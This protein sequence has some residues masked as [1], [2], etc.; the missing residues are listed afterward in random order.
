MCSQLSRCIT[1]SSSGQAGLLPSTSPTPASHQLSQSPGWEGRSHGQLVEQPPWGTLE[2]ITWWW[3]I[4]NSY[5]SVENFILC[6]SKQIS[7]SFT[8]TRGKRELH[9]TASLWNSVPYLGIYRLDICYFD[10]NSSPE[11]PESSTILSRHAFRL[12]MQCNW[13]GQTK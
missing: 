7:L 10:S 8:G 4:S 6:I 3:T 12:I 2:A 11:S 9:Q 1:F 5:I 13:Q